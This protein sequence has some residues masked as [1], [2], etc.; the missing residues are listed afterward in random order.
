MKIW[1]LKMSIFERTTYRVGAITSWL[2]VLFG[3]LGLTL[4]APLL[5]ES[6]SGAYSEYANDRWTIQFLLSAPVFLGTVFIL[7]V[8]FLLRLA[9][10]NEMFSNSS[11]K[12]VRLLAGTGFALSASIVAIGGWLSV[13]NTLPPLLALVIAVSFLLVTA[14]SLVTLSLF[15]LLKRATFVSDELE[16]VI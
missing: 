10:K 16:G 14:T 3:I 6:L 5:S 11:F 1:S 4:V 9:Y 2:L 12:W 8:L 13:K 15:S 7:E